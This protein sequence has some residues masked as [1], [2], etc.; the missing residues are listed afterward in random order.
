[1][2]SKW[3]KQRKEKK[4]N[5]INGEENRSASTAQ[6]ASGISIINGEMAII[7]ASKNNG[8]I[9]GNGVSAMAVSWRK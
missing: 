1:V 5:K 4:A 6:Q 7:S 8:G 9:S 2:K 3:R